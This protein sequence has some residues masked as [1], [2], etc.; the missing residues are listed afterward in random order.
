MNTLS[1]NQ[2]GGEFTVLSTT[3]KDDAL[4][5]RSDLLKEFN[6][7]W[8]YVYNFNNEMFDVKVANN[9]GAKLEAHVLKAIEKF[10]IDKKLVSSPK[11][12]KKKSVKKEKLD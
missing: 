3:N 8:V 6:R 5:L 2:E 7:L 12:D 4:T 11:S 10:I 1:N 9:W